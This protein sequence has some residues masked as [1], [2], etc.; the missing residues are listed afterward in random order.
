LGFGGLLVLLVF[1][2]V[3]GWDRKELT[4]CERF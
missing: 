3:E 2:A 1:L 4:L